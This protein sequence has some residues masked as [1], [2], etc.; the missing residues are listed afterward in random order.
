MDFIRV[1]KRAYLFVD[2]WDKFSVLED[3][4][5]YAGNHYNLKTIKSAVDLITSDALGGSFDYYKMICEEVLL[6]VQTKLEAS[7]INFNKNETRWLKINPG[8]TKEDIAKEISYLQTY[9]ENKR[10]VLKNIN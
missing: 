3:L 4:G 9:V 5:K 2:R 1:Y 8:F 6:E 7:S 10:N